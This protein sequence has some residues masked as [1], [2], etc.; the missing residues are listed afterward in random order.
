MKSKTATQILYDDPNSF[1]RASKTVALHEL[2]GATLK[3]KKPSIDD[4]K[5]SLV[6]E[7]KMIALINEVQAIDTRFTWLSQ[8][9]GQV[10]FGMISLEVTMREILKYIGLATA[11]LRIVKRY[12]TI[13]QDDL[14]SVYSTAENI[15][16]TFQNI[17]NMKDTDQLQPEIENSPTFNRL[18]ESIAKLVASINTLV[19]TQLATT[20]TTIETRPVD[21]IP[22]PEPPV[23]DELEAEEF[24]GG[25]RCYGGQLG[26]SSGH[27]KVL[28]SRAREIQR[29]PYK[30]FI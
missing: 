16:D 27:F 25:M 29:H 26:A 3:T 1:F 9:F 28:S 20:S 17:K 10:Q 21:D 2:Q 24:V 6:V 15:Y 18:M 14:Q 30:R 12:K 7:S 19:Q 22:P 23:Q 13:P 11:S 8:N 4:V 5:E